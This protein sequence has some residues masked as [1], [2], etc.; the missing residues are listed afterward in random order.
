MKKFLLLCLFLALPAGFAHATV[1]LSDSFDYADGSLV[2]VSSGKWGHHSGNTTGEVDVVS[3][4]VF[5]T[6]AES[7]DV[8]AVLSNGPYSSGNLY[9]RFTV[10]FSAL[11]SGAGTYFAHF[12]DNGSSGFRAKIFV[13]TDGAAGGYYR[14]GIGN[15][16]NTAS[17]V[18][19]TDLALNGTYTLVVRYDAGTPVTTIWLNPSSESDTNNATATD[20]A[21][22]LGIT[23][24]ALRQSL[25]SGNGMG[26]LYLDDLVVG[27][28]FSDVTSSASNSA[29]L[30]TLQPQSQSVTEG[31][32]VAFTVAA[33]G[34][35]TPSYQWQFNGTNLDGATNTTL[36][37]TNVTVAQEGDYIAV[38]SNTAGTTNSQPAA[39]AIES[40]S[41]PATT[42]ISLATYNVKGNGVSDWSTNS[43][44]VQAIGRQMQYL[45]PDIVTFQEIPYDYPYEMTNFINVFLPGYSLARNSGTDGYIRSVIASRFPITRSTKWL[46]GVSLVAF[47][48]DGTFTRDL[49]EAQITVPNFEQPLHVFTV[50]LKSGGT[51]DDIARRAGEAAAITNFFATNF[52]VLYPTHPYVLTGDMNESNT[53]A[54][55]IKRLLSIPTGL[56]LTNPTNPVTHSINTYSIQGSLTVRLDYIMPCG[57]L[58]SNIFSSQ[59][60]RTDLLTNPPP[61]LLTNDDRTASDH[62]PVMMVFGNPFNAPFRL[63]SVGVS[64]QFVTLKWE[65]APGRHYRVESSSNLTAWADLA[66]N[67]VATGT[68]L[69]FTTNA[70]PTLQFY[71]VYR[72]P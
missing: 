22:T 20:T 44:Q 41:Q 14:I 33:T 68:N 72:W 45:Q 62:L 69:T 2:T 66:T 5:L 15:V 17:G 64:N 59:V 37:L 58:Y 35:P 46:D 9:A 10:N 18:I 3:G 28:S 65:S 53:N 38:V 42:I 43:P 21:A 50:H 16:T 52:F 54:L 55:S 7:E 27:T 60:F 40:S 24:F 29:P 26:S 30:I 6:Q 32:A 51:S 4:R 11:P 56:R 49:F 57:L 71:R 19:A 34:N 39:L 36:L 25:S 23:T 47:G 48:Y 67:L 1:L 12:K 70:A 61:P 31:V 8:S 13:T 63:L